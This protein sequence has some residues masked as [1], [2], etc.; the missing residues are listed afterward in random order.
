MNCFLSLKD[1]S[2]FIIDQDVEDNY[3][4]SIDPRWNSKLFNIIITSLTPSFSYLSSSPNLDKSIKIQAIYLM[5]HN[6]YH[7]SSHFPTELLDPVSHLPL[8]CA[9]VTPSGKMYNEQTCFEMVNKTTKMNNENSF[10]QQE[11]QKH[12]YPAWNVR[13]LVAGLLLL[14]NISSK[15]KIGGMEEDEDNQEILSQIFLDLKNT[16]E[17]C[18]INFEML[19]NELDD[20]KRDNPKVKLMDNKNKIQLQI[21]IGNPLSIS[22]T[23]E[24]SKSVN[25][26]NMFVAVLKELWREFNNTFESYQTLHSSF[27]DNLLSI[28]NDVISNNISISLLDL[29]KNL[30]ELSKLSN[31]LNSLILLFIQSSSLFSSS[32]SSS[33]SGRCFLNQEA[34]ENRN[35]LNELIQN[36]QKLLNK[37]SQL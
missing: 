17:Q 25:S 14:L 18:S 37:F 29:Y 7:H 33:S 23:D 19:M 12:C 5:M 30:I 3:T 28:G 2:N 27:S 34:I 36:E 31:K 6:F 9:V 21:E 8:L 20:F 13:N 11:F 22:L 1:N 16:A 4:N 24:E 10:V 15:D 32:D 26:E 35:R